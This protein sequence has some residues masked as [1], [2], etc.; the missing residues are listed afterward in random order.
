MRSSDYLKLARD[1]LR[2]A[3][4]AS[5]KDAPLLREIAQTW[6]ELAKTAAAKG[7]ATVTKPDPSTD[8]TTLH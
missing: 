8:T 5:P 6:V 7:P 4:T 1:C 3:G 2:M